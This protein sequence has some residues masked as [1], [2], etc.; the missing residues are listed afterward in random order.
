MKFIFVYITNPTQKEAEK[1]AKH[2]LKKRLVACVNFFP[3]KSFYW[4]EGEILSEKEFGLIAKT[5]E[6]NYPKIVKELEKNHPYSIPCIAKIPVVFNKK[7]EE[8]LRKEV[9]K[10]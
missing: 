1:I 3:V 7:Y 5:K 6:G 8:W 4:W 2:L 10:V 9:D